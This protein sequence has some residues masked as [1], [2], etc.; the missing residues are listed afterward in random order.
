MKDVSNLTCQCGRVPS[1]DLAM[2][3]DE[4]EK[5]AFRVSLRSG[6]ADR[7]RCD[8]RAIAVQYLGLRLCPWPGARSRLDG[9]IVWYDSR[10]SEQA[11][12]YFVAHEIGHY[13]LSGE[14]AGPEL[15]RAC[16]RIGAALILPG[17]SFLRDVLEL[18]ALRAVVDCWPLS[19]RRMARMRISELSDDV[20]GVTPFL[21]VRQ[22]GPED[23]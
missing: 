20:G 23:E 8:P 15:E 3:A 16:S 5:L 7:P 21:R 1:V 9:A 13:L 18:R 12:A 22:R 19:T 11:Q 6:R 2:E 17:P 10:G 4:L 14:P